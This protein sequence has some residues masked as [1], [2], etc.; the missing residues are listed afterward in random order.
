MSAALLAGTPAAAQDVGAAWRKAAPALQAA[1]SGRLQWL[2]FGVYDAQLWV[3]PGFRAGAF[4]SHAFALEL[5][6]LR[7]FSA[8]DIARR[9]LQEMRRATRIETEDAQGWQAALQKVLP[10]VRAGDRVTG[11]HLPGKGLRFF[12]N[13]R[14]AGDIADARFAALFFGIW[15][16]PTTSEPQLRA[17][18]LE[19]AGR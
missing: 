4:E 5:R 6:Y 11:L 13:G 14:P 19:G 1:G 12:V 10:D 7:D 2:A 17:A 9:S 8:T 3:E 18:L 15:L 16:A